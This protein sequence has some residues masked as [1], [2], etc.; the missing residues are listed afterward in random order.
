M[1]DNSFQDK[2]DEWTNAVPPEVTEHACDF[3]VKVEEQFQRHIEEKMDLVKH[4]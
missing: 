3:A 1:S 2:P 4:L